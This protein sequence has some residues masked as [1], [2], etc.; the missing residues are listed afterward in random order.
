VGLKLK[1]EV[2][3]EVT[4]KVT[5]GVRVVVKVFGSPDVLVG[6]GVNV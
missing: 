2:A 3:V 5:V 1:V 6:V 4:V